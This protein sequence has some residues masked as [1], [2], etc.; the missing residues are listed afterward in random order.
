M[1]FISQT[2]YIKTNFLDWKCS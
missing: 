1:A 2:T